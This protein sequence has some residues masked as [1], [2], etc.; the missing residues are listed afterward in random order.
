[1][2]T[3]AFASNYDAGDATVLSYAYLFASY[4]VAGTGFALGMSRIADMRRGALA[5]WREVI[6]DTVPAG[7]RYS[8]LLVAPALA[9]LI[10]GGA[11]A[12]RRGPA[13]QLRRRRRSTQLQV[14]A[15]LLCA[16]TVA[17]L[18]VNLL[19]PAMFALGRAK[20]VNLLA[21]R[22]RRP[23]H[24]GHRARRR[25][26]RRQRRRRRLLRRA[27]RP[28]P[29]SCSLVGAGRESGPIARELARDGLRF[30]PPAA[31]CFGIGAAI[32]TALA[33]GLVDAAR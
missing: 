25:P 23:A 24:R 12:D 8:M 20:L 33:T 3:L 19:L 11:T 5:D 27:P 18:L 10:A 7:F 6:A 30:A 28:S 1:M 15:A 16:W 13:R 26:L 29:S 9:A 14:F 21:L 2:I 31:A 32:G 4:L 17:A 22:G